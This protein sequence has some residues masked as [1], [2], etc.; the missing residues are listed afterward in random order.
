MTGLKKLGYDVQK[1]AESG[2]TY[3]RI[4]DINGGIYF[5]QTMKRLWKYKPYQSSEV[6]SRKRCPY[7]NFIAGKTVHM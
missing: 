7:R 1:S 4:L 3:I 5:N 6:S 2:V